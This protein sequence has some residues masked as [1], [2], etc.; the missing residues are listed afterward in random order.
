MKKSLPL[1]KDGET[2]AKGRAFRQLQGFQEQDFQRC[3]FLVVFGCNLL[4]YDRCNAI[5]M[6]VAAH[7]SSVLLFSWLD[8]FVAS[9]LMLKKRC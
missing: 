3:F 9:I 2:A 1:R 4:A 7:G 6:N 8:M 5:L